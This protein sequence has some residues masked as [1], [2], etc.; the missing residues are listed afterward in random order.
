[1]TIYPFV[2]VQ[3]DFGYSDVTVQNN[4]KKGLISKFFEDAGKR[5]AV[6]RDVNEKYIQKQDH[7]TSFSFVPITNDQLFN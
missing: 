2:S 6:Y 3:K 5:L 4:E 7:K 1:M